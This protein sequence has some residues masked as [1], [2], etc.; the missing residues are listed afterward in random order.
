MDL[1]RETD[2]LF[3]RSATCQFTTQ[4]AA[5]VMLDQPQ[6]WS[7]KLIMSF[8]IRFRSQSLYWLLRNVIRELGQQRSS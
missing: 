3:E 6:G 5:K 4:T 8:P 1:G 7:Q 2:L